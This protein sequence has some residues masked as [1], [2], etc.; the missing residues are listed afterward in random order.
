[1]FGPQIG[2]LVSG[3][4]SPP[5]KLRVKSLKVTCGASLTTA[6]SRPVVALAWTL[7]S[8]RTEIP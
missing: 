5:S 1:M 4:V 7:P 3:A 8:S 6:V 2:G